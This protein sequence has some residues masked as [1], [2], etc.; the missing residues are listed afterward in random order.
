MRYLILN[1]PQGAS[2]SPSNA[3]INNVNADLN[4]RGGFTYEDGLFDDAVRTTV[5]SGPSAGL[6]IEV[7]MGSSGK[8]FAVDY[9]YRSTKPWDGIHTFG[10]RFSL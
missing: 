8:K 4:L 9:A 1:Y 3:I 2:F 5:Y 7:P 10:V 6:T